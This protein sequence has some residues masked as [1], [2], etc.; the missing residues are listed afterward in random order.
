[1]LISGSLLTLS[2]SSGKLSLT[3]PQFTG[4][5]GVQYYHKYTDLTY[6]LAEFGTGLSYTTFKYSN[7]V[8]N[9]TTLIVGDGLKVSV[10]VKNSGSREG[11]EVVLLVRKD[12]LG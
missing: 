7:L 9:T 12:A 1:M 10:D 2:Y 5:V 11:K 6:P 3:Y 8:L 4:D